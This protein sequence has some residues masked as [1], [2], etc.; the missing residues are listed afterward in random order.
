MAT[1]YGTIPSQTK[2]LT[3]FPL[4]DCLDDGS[5]VQISYMKEEHF[6]Q[7]HKLLNTI[8]EDGKTYPQ[9]Q[10]LSRSQ[11]QSYFQTAFVI[12]EG[13]EVLGGFYVK[14]NF[15]G[16][17]G[18]ICNGGFIVEPKHRGRG[19]G[20]SLGRAFL[21]IAPALGYHASIFNLVFESNTASV[22]LWKGLGFQIIGTV[23]KAGRLLGCNT[24]TD[25]FIFYYK[26]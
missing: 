21:K 25:A 20:K 8:I 23:P 3:F 16:R 6:D 9:E 14:P 19:V 18:H 2:L 15:P 7:M 26:F 24:L 4:L 1:P 10:Q 22:K 5:S 12:M 17:C 11:F 13:S